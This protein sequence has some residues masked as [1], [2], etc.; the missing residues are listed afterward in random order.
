MMNKISLN[1][2][3]KFTYEGNVIENVSIPFSM[4]SV[5]LDNGLMKDPFYRDNE[6][7]AT[8]MSKKDCD[9]EIKF[10]IDAEAVSKE[11]QYLIM[12]G[13]DTACDIE[14]NGVSLG[15]IKDMH[16]RFKFPV[17]GI[18]KE[19]ENTLKIHFNSPL[20]YIRKADENF[21]KNGF[22]RMGA[23]HARL[24]KTASMN[25]WDWGPK[26][27]DMG[28]YK[29][30][31]IIAFDKGIL[32]NVF[33]RQIH[34]DNGS[35]TL[36]IFAEAETLSENE[37]KVTVASPEN[38]KFSVTLTDGYGEIIIKN[39]LLWWPNGYGEQNLYSVH[40]ELL[41][42]GK[43][44]DTKDFNIG[45][46]TVKLF[47][48]KDKFGREFAFEVNG[49]RIFA[50]GANYIPEDNLIPRITRETSEKLIKNCIKANFNMI[51]IWGGGYYGTD[52]FYDLC[53][54]Y[55]ILVWQDFMFA[56]SGYLLTDEL[57]EDIKE[58]A[59]CNLIRI[60]NHPSL[61][62][63][64]GNNEIEQ[65]FVDFKVKENERMRE[66]Y[67]ELFLGI[68]KDAA[69]K[70]VPDIS[71]WHSS[72]SNGNELFDPTSDPDNGDVHNWDVWHGGKPF[73]DYRRHHFR[74]CSEYGFEG[75]ANL[76]TIKY[77]TKEDE[78]NP[79]GRIM[80]SHQKCYSGNGKILTY[81][82]AT[83]LY[84]NGLDNLVYA[85]QL[86]QA[87]AIRYGVEH[88]RRD[89]GRCMGSL[90]WQ[91]NDCWPTTSWSSIDYFGRW[92]GLHYAAKNFYAPVLLS[93][94][95]DWHSVTL[96]L[97]NE[98][99]NE[100]K[101][102]IVYGIFES[103]N[104]EVMRGEMQVSIP[105]L[106]SKDQITLELEAYLKGNEYNR[107][108]AFMLLDETGNLISSSSVL[109]RQPKHFEFKKP[110]I[111][112]EFKENDGKIEIT[113]NSDVY[114]KGVYLEFE[115]IDALFSDN[116][117]D[118]TAL[119]GKA[120]TVEDFAFDIKRSKETLKIKSVYDMDK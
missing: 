54:R 100:F 49:E 88:F 51:R 22:F 115:G 40:A 109:F 105:K 110:N 74:F 37:I 41:S 32:D 70:Y 102:K 19:G 120:I 27:P 71:Y 101:G 93:A 89:R 60:R 91:L 79:F 106:T 82:A 73:K 59:K 7:K 77:F 65:V 36:N 52:D 97:A 119:S 18:I 95:E 24:R 78:R 3:W 14:L 87:D 81:L 25:G 26:L 67:I 15:R 1:S 29:P 10:N 84:P 117:F 4:Y 13:V 83:Y 98:T 48:N 5:M 17:N 61:A 30:M 80:E 45:L 112:A 76:K 69:E 12:D 9:A 111:T 35:V 38:E 44:L 118:L 23:G 47:T 90:Y 64:C 46:R 53:D 42:N 92:K 6:Y 57:R 104:R 58:E 114:A 85:S 113:L 116:Y 43:S 96:N 21:N 33:I 86:L 55:G 103:D 11:R 28:I 34:N 20:E 107:Y 75:F 2:G 66:D 8:E 50:M 108:F 63:L 31:E 68:L 62:L 16:R 99:R 56:C 39:P 72:P 94:H